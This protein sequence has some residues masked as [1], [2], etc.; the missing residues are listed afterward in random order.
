ML[1]INFL[2]WRKKKESERKGRVL[3]FLIFVNIV[4]LA[5]MIWLERSGQEKI[6]I[7]RKRNSFLANQNEILEEKI[8]DYSRIEKEKHVLVEKLIVLN[9]IRA[10]QPQILKG[11]SEGL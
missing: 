11:L 3:L 8:K 7:Q 10:N 1:D 4:I 2:P 5:G 6:I 9:Q